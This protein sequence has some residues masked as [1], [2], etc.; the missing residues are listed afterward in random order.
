MKSLFALA[1]LGTI[2]SANYVHEFGKKTWQLAAATYCDKDS[3]E[4]WSCG[5]ACTRNSAIQEISLIENP[6]KNTFGFT[7]YESDTN[8]I[9]VV[10][11]GT[12]NPR[13][14]ITNV[15]AYLS[16][17][18]NHS[19]AKVHKGFKEAYMAVADD[20]QY[21]VNELLIRHP[22]AELL[23]TGHSLGGALAVIAAA[24]IKETFN[25][26][27]K[28]SLYTFGAPRVGNDPFAALLFDY[29]PSGSQYRVINEDDAV[30]HN[31]PRSKTGFLHSG[32]EVWYKLAGSSSFKLCKNKASD[33]SENKK[34][35]HSLLIKTGISTHL[36][37]FGQTADDLCD[38]REG[39][40][41]VM[42]EFDEFEFEDEVYEIMSNF[43]EQEDAFEEFLQNQK[44]AS[45]FS[46]LIDY[47]PR[48]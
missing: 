42:N 34:C 40:L 19:S 17:W 33:R 3:V 39:D 24:D 25:V 23:F 9:L 5:E 13:N 30:P 6:S 37:Y 44:E 29:Y 1:A 16:K 26:S 28:M 21:Q 36:N 35:S 22:N 38:K 12:I 43:Q 41:A 18:K 20:V 15:T 31:P 45:N 10:F 11:R 46:R 27:N 47:V 14:W 7:A 4:N 2:A 8:T 48:D 32:D